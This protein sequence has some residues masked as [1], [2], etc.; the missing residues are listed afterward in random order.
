MN[1]QQKSQKF[2][3]K[4]FLNFL[5][6]Q[7]THSSAYDLL[8]ALRSETFFMGCQESNLARLYASHK[9]LDSSAFTPPSFT[10]HKEI[11]NRARLFY[12]L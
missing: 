5:G 8:L 11:V 12:L 7:A 9:C 6:I 4:G 3:L 1:N 10:K 2:Y